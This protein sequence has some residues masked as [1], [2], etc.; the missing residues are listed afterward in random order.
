MEKYIK[1]KKK[2]MDKI[3]NEYSVDIELLHELWDLGYDRGI[4]IENKIKEVNRLQKNKTKVPTDLMEDYEL[5]ITTPDN[6][7]IEL[8]IDDFVNGEVN[9]YY[10]Y[11][12]EN[13]LP[14][15]REIRLHEFITQ[16]LRVLELK[17][18]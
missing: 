10:Y 8:T 14:R 4:D 12:N 1:Y 7:Q 2:L 9:S 3:V 11:Q 5:Q 15:T 18:D 13:G 16:V 6:R 17:R